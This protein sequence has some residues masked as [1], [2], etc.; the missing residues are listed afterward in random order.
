MVWYVRNGE[1][2][3]IGNRSQGWSTAIVD[4]AVAYDE[5]ID[6]AI[7]VMREVVHQM[8]Q[9]PAWQGRLLEEPTVVG[10]ESIAAGAVTVRIIAKCAPNENFAGAA[11]D[12][13]AAQGGPGPQRHP[14]PAAGAVRRRRA[15][16]ERPWSRTRHLRLGP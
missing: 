16:R 2:V 1:I 11:R 13:R 6:R 12:P 10:V 3:R 7:T 4:T 14:R 8:D 15:R 5:D 9:D